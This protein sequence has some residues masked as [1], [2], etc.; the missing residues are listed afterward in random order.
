MVI[1]VAE[2]AGKFEL[3]LGRNMLI[4]ENDNQMAQPNRINFVE[5]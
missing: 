2:P 4:V 5:G 3:L 1:N